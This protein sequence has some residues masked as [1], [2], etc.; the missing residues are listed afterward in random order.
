MVIIIQRRTQENPRKFPTVLLVY[1]RLRFR[2]KSKHLEA[3][4]A[5]EFEVNPRFVS[6][7]LVV[8]E[9]PLGKK[10]LVIILSSM[11]ET[12]SVPRMKVPADLKLEAFSR[13]YCCWCCTM[14]DSD[15]DPRYLVLISL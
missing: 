11:V 10:L 13:C 7:T 6:L 2:V 1:G 3:I 12:K 8:S 9:E 4:L 5:Q 15:Y 14:L